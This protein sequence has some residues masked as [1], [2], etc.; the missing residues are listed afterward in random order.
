MINKYDKKYYCQAICVDF[1]G[2][3][4]EFSDNIN[5]FGKIIDGA[6]AALEKLR[7]LGYK[8][9]IHTTRPSDED[10]IT[11][12]TKYLKAHD[13]P[14]DEINTNS[15]SKWP[16]AKPVADLYIDDRALRFEGNWDDTVQKAQYYLGL[17]KSPYKHFT[18]E[19]LLSKITKRAKEVKKFEEFLRKETAW[20]SAPASTRF[21]LPKEGGLVEH[22]LNVANTI[23][24]LK[25]TLAPDMSD[26]SCVIVAL[27]HDIGKIGMP[28]KPYYLPNTNLWLKEKRGIHYVVN[29]E[30]THMDQATRSLYLVASYIPLS[31]D[32]AQAI[33]YHDG[34]YVEE[35]RSVAN[36]E[37][38]ITRLLQYADNWSGMVIELR[39]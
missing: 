17:T 14:F 6:G 24:T 35:N 12:L 25:K 18:Y 38:K 16:S 30:L 1:D 7:A 5:D 37:S 10:H 31:D 13:I 22:S 39:G 26:E 32:E 9:I 27:Y 15:D 11:E 2:V 33:R 19:E 20:L 8:I 28:G 21:H 34:Q 3:I 29:Q 4:A 23:L 36:K